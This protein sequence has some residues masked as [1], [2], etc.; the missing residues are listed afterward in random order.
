MTHTIVHF[1]IPADDVERA[2]AFYKDLFGWQTEAPPGFSDYWLIETGPEGQAVGGGLFK[3]Q[4]PDQG[5]VNYISV[6]SV[7]EYAS[8]IEQLGGKIIMPRSPVPGMGWFA[9]FQ[10]TEKNVLA[11]WESDPAAS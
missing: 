5:I 9:V 2:R 6:E 8:R 11:L 1:E 7:A 3:R 10:D 4:M